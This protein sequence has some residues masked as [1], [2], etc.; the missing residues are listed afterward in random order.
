MPLG[1]YIHVPFCSEICHYCDFAKTA[2]FSP[3]LVD[4]YFAALLAHTKAWLAAAERAGLLPLSTVFFGGGTPGLFTSTYAPLMAAIRPHLQ[5]GAELSLE[6]NPDNITAEALK[7]WRDLGFNRLSIGIQ[8]FAPAGIE[9]LTRSHSSDVAQATL[10][11]ARQH[12]P[13]LNADLIYG[14]PGQT[15][16][17]WEQDL[18]LCH[19]L[20]VP[21]LSLYNLTYEPRTAIGRRERRGR[22]EPMSDDDQHTLFM[23]AVAALKRRGY[24][25]EEV[26]NWALPGFSCEHNW[27]YWRSSPYLAIGAGA[28][29]F[30][31]TT[32]PWGLR[33]RYPAKP[34]AFARLKAPEITDLIATA[35]SSGAVIEE[36]DASD[37][38]L[39]YVGCGLRT[40]EG[41]DIA[42]A[43][44]QSGL[45]FV[46][47][48][49]VSAGLAK[50]LL[51]LSDAAILTLSPT[52]WF[53]ENAWSAEVAMSFV[54]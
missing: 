46:P 17:Q 19:Q 43:K 4:D 3:S 48:P 42:A 14:W 52:E 21:H 32:D 26:S 38:L 10:D 30:I 12:F 54:H 23:T 53:R 16:A 37:W 13:N 1:L 31:P 8:S 47:R 2:N 34:Q 45:R 27:L 25:H 24:V 22:I 18:A 35:Q 6:A 51:T 49:I 29:G 20:G 15:I 9:F 39:E 11:L 41:L 33:Y 7:Q 36:R 5:S 28:A 44:A 40:C 50:G